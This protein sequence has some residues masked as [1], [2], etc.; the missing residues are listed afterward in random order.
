MKT[1]FSA[2]H[3]LHKSPGELLYSEFVPAF[4]KP[5][6]AE[7]ILARVKETNL[8]EV[9]SP[10]AFPV[11]ELTKIH[12]SGLVSLLMTGHEEWAA[13]G[14]G[15]AAYPYTWA[16]RGMRTGRVPNNLD[17]RLG[18]YSFDCGTPI[19][20][21][22]W[23]AIKS[24][25]DV[26][27]TGAE[28]VSAGE[29]AVFALCRPP[30]HHAGSD[31]FGGYCFLNNAALAAQKLRDDGAERVAILDVD[32]HHGNGTQQIFYQRNDVLVVNIHGDPDQEYP[33]MLG[34]ADEPGAGAGE[35]FNLNLPLP[36]GTEWAE[37][38]AALQAG[39][40]RVA[41][42]GPD[43]VVVSLGVD[44]FKN[45]PISKFRLEHE[46]FTAMGGMIAELMKP[47]LFVM[48]GGYAVVEI[49]VNAVNVL[50]GFDDS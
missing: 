35:G 50:T 32:Y 34:F 20:A 21:T 11:A 2:D 31:H 30:G 44:T 25:A 18:Y 42:F 12:A 49:G 16:A 40:Q 9:L 10:K 36:W 14:R 38:R 24:S 15:G 17:G 33:Y 37:W 7:L 8:G 28:L 41:A 22:S 26:A 48:E 23:Q 5:E 29:K 43:A 45:D 3:A 6:R 19:T 47:V 46:H 27:M 13:M 1:V 4:E 39:I